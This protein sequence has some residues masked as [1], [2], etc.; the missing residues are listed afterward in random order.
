[1]N[2]AIPNCCRADLKVG[3]YGWSLKVGPTDGPLRSAPT[4]GFWNR[5]D[6]VRV[7]SIGLADR[8]IGDGRIPALLDDA[9]RKH[10]VA[11]IIGAVPVAVF[12]IGGH[13]GDAAHP[14]L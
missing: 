7:V 9:L 6:D 8:Q 1:M 11:E 10:D 2:R 12:G 5:Q 4:D 14:R 13:R 3:P